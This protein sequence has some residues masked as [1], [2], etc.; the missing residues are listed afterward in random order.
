M[1]PEEQ[2]NKFVQ[3]VYLTWNN[4]YL[5]D[6]TST[7]GQMEVDKTIDRCNLFLQELELEADWQYLRDNQYLLGTV[8]GADQSFALPDGARKLV[9]HEDRPLIITQDDTVVSEWHVVDPSIL[10]EDSDVY[11]DRVATVGNRVVFSRQL[12]DYEQSGSVKAD[13]IR[14][15][16]ELSRTDVSVL[17]LVK[18]TQ[19][20]I[21]GMIKNLVLPDIVKGGLTPS[22]TEKY[23]DLLSKAI[24]ENNASAEA[25]STDR[26]DNSYIAGVY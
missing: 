24:M 25:E 11:R 26:T 3:Q 21:L 16:P 4:R 6:I 13:I 18:P 9:V 7:A 17:D 19:L 14:N 2:L 10:K 20:V 23:A 22:Y 15:M 5:N 12:Q 1:T 8:S